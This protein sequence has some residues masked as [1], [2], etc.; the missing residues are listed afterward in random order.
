MQSYKELNKKG[1]NERVAVHLN[2]AMYDHDSFL[3][4]RSSLTTYETDLLGDVDGK[5][6]LHLQCHFGQ[7]TI[8]LARLG[9]SVV[10]VDFSDKAI[11][12]A[13]QTASDLGADATFICCDVH[14]LP[15]HLEEQFD[16]VFCSYGIISWHPDMAAWSRLVSQFIKPGGRHVFVEFHPA[17]WMWDDNYRQVT[18]SYFNRDVIVEE[19]QGTYADLNADMTISSACWNHSLA[20]V[21]QNFINCG[22][23]LRTFHEHPISPFHLSES[24]VATDGGYYIKG[25]EDKLPL[26][27]ALE[28]VAP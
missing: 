6:I 1:W 14:E 28:F 22:L 19:E 11:E 24:M 21:I 17:M 12:V 23:T 3:K 5:R 16:I 2:S 27:F 8:S 10:G 13:R 4:G 18:Y 7:D 25:M 20:D 15:Q 9:A 26:V